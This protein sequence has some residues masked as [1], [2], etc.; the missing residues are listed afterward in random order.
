MDARGAF[1][2][3]Q[4]TGGG[5]GGGSSTLSRPNKYDFI[6]VGDDVPVSDVREIIRVFGGEGEEVVAVVGMASV[7]GEEGAD[8]V[9][10]CSWKK[11]VTT[12][13][14]RIFTSTQLASIVK[15]RP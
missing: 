2:I 3:K 1:A 9:M 12:D 13:V 4:A 15:V 11:G 7:T 6:L 8:R 5:G 10:S 14:H